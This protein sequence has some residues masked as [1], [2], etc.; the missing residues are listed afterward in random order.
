MDMMNGGQLAGGQSGLVYALE[1]A[2]DECIDD[3][4]SVKQ[5][6]AARFYR[7]QRLLHDIFNEIVVPDPRHIVTN[8]RYQQLKKQSQSIEKHHEKQCDELHALE[9]AYEAKK[10][11]L[12]DASANFD[13]EMNKVIEI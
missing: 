6:A 5:V 11:K 4:P 10:A 3:T 2:E 1:P 9:K 8:Q 7:N 12:S 13:K